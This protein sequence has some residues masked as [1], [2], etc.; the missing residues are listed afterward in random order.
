M[1]DSQ[2]SSAPGPRDETLASPP[3]APSKSAPR[4]PGKVPASSDA[5]GAASGT[6]EAPADQTWR[7]PTASADASPHAHLIP[8][9]GTHDATLA[10]TPPESADRTL[11][12]PAPPGRNDHTLRVSNVDPRNP[13]LLRTRGDEATLLAGSRASSGPPADPRAPA[14]ADPLASEGTAFGRF[15][16]L[17]KLGAGGMGIVYQAYDPGLRRTFALKQIRPEADSPDV[18][19]RFLREARLAALGKVVRG[20][21]VGECFDPDSPVDI[22]RAIAALARDPDRRRRCRDNTARFRAE[23]DPAEEWRRLVGVYRSM[24]AACGSSP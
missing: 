4:G 8:A 23:N 11:A 7:A 22:G 18:L 17:S 12:A 14:Q 21:E 16:L 10:S 15:R 9:P 20:Y 2:P 3:P 13:T 1:S 5:G 24:K 19:Q 6:P